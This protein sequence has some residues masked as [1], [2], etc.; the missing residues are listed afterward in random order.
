ML[1]TIAIAAVGAA[2]GDLFEVRLVGG[3]AGGVLGT[4]LGFVIVW[5]RWVKPEADAARARDYSK[6]GLR[7]IKDDDDDEW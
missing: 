3:L 1:T 7:E 4:V 2:I 6:L 5:K